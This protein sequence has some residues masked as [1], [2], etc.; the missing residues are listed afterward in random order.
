VQVAFTAA[1]PVGDLVR[2]PLAPIPMHRGGG[3]E[4]RLARL[5]EAFGATHEFAG[6]IE[7]T[8]SDGYRFRYVVDGA[9]VIEIEVSRAAGK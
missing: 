8:Y 6:F 3:V 5:V 7:V 9:E 4:K 1:G 2:G